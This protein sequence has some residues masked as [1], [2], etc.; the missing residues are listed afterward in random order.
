MMLMHDVFA[1]A[2]FLV[3]NSQWFLVVNSQWLVIC[4]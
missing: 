3:V 4:K 1:I 2:K